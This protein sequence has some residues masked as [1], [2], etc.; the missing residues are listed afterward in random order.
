MV[1]ITVDGKEYSVD[2]NK[3]LVDALKEVGIHIPTFCYHPKLSVAGLCRLCLIEIEGVP[4]LQIGCGTAVKDGMK[5][6]VTSEKIIK[7]REAIMEFQLIN[8]PLDCPV[9]DKAGECKLQ[10][11]SFSSGTSTT[12]YKENKRT[13]PEEEIGDNLLINH[14]RCIMCLRCVRFQKEIL[15]DPRLER[16]HR[17][18]QSMIGCISNGKD[19]GKKLI[20]HNYQGALSDLCPVGALL[21]KD[22]LY[23]SRVW[24]YDRTQSIC[25][26]CSSLCK[27]TVD[28]KNNE[29]YRYMPPEDPYNN[30]Y[31]I[32]D[33]GRFSAEDFTKERL[34]SYAYKGINKKSPDVFSEIKNTWQNAQSIVFVGGT[35]ESNE[36]LEKIKEIIQSMI[37]T[38]KNVK[39]EYKTMQ[40]MWES[41][42]AEEVDFLM[43]SDKRP[44]SKKAREVIEGPFSNEKD[45]IAALKNADIIFSLNEFSAPYSYRIN[46]ENE[47]SENIL[48]KIF[49]NEN[50]WGKIIN[51]TTHDNNASKKALASFPVKA[52]TEIENSFTDKKGEIKKT[53]ISVRPPE[54]L[55]NTAEVLEYFIN[56]VE[57]QTAIA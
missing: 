10:D 22:M 30:G 29:V 33:Q 47:L 39:W 54:G 56:S 46:D 8:H 43:T 36:S 25:H 21:N 13:T 17:G 48:Y 26:G 53:K 20:D 40:Y 45:F 28:V 51:L 5:I 55:R 11:Y 42:W 37:K 15:N 32:C 2:E 52:M 1:T 44:N 24:W 31:F 23:K 27:I 16:I 50:L 35:T 57:R 4:K 6:I 34:F 7:A 19:E 9:C 49:E 12:R 14:N 38:G 3:N 41:N 18:N